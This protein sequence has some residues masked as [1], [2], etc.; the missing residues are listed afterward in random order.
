MDQEWDPNRG[1]L[2]L[3]LVAQYELA[4]RLQRSAEEGKAA[5][6][7]QGRISWQRGA[8]TKGGGCRQGVSV[9]CQTWTEAKLITRGELEVPRLRS[10]QSGT[11]GETVDEVQIM[12]TAVE[13]VGKRRR[14]EGLEETET[15]TAK[16]G[17]TASRPTPGQGAQ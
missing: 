16:A 9:E 7:G 8:D 12:A 4:Q 15:R 3:E 11:Q 6:Q 10:R 2:N 17:T 14:G 5:A 1:N 13:T